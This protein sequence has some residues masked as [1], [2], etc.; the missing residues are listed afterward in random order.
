M[1][2]NAGNMVNVIKQ[3][4]VS[5]ERRDLLTGI[6]PGLELKLKKQKMALTIAVCL[7][8]AERKR[9]FLGDWSRHEK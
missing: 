9:V 4:N 2:W 6:S 8:Q 1:N 3:R 7:C 5:G